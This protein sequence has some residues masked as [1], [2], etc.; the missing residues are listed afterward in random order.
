MENC[1]DVGSADTEWETD[2]D[3]IPDLLSVLNGDNGPDLIPHKYDAE[4]AF[5]SYTTS[6]PEQFFDNTP[7][8]SKNSNE[9]INLQ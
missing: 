4:A 8:V 6:I 3:T 7:S 1:N 2:N 9:I 5:Y